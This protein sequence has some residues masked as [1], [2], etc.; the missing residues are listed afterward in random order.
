MSELEGRIHRPF[1]SA[2]SYLDDPEQP[3]APA[4]R[5]SLAGWLRTAALLASPARA[6]IT[7]RNLAIWLRAL[8]DPA[9]RE[10]IGKLFDADFY[11]SSYDDVR[12]AGVHPL[13]HY[14]V[15]GFREGRSPSLLLDNDAYLS[16]YDDV[17][18]SGLNPLLHYALFG[19]GEARSLLPVRSRVIDVIEGQEWISG[20]FA[21]L[22]NVWP[23]GQPLV[24]V[25]IPCFNYGQFVEQALDSVLSQTFANFEVI[26]VEGGSTDGITA[27]IVAG[28]E[29]R[30][31]PKVRVFYRT[32][33]RLVGDNRNFGIAR[34]RGRYVC[35]LDADDL[36]KP[37]YLEMAVFLAESCGFDV[38][39]S[40][41]KCF[42]D[43]DIRWMLYDPSFP[44]ICRHNQIATTALFRRSAWERIGGYRD[45]GLGDEHIP[46]DWDFWVRMLGHGFR[47]KSI[48]EPLMYY[49]V[50]GAGL[51]AT[52]ETDVDLQRDSILRANQAL[53]AAPVEAPAQVTVEIANRWVNLLTPPPDARPAV[54]VALPFITVGGAEQLFHHV[55]QGLAERGAR[56]I[57]VTTVELP[58]SI[59][60][61]ADRYNDITPQ[62]YHL[63]RLLEADLWGDFVRYLIGH[64]EVGGIL[65]AGSEFLHHQL[66]ALRQRFPRLRI[67]DQ[68]FNDAGHI[69][70]NR[71]YAGFIDRTLVPSTALR[72]VLTGQ[73]GEAAERIRVIPHGV[74]TRPA[75]WDRG[76]ALEAAGLPRAAEGRL[77]VSFFGRMSKEK[78]PET[79]VEIAAQLAHRKDLYFLMTG[80][81]PEWEAVKKLA[82]RHK[83]GNSLWMPGFV[84]DPRPLMELTDMVALTSTLDGMPLTVLEAG[85]LG[86][87]VVASRVGSLAEMVID[88]ETGLLRAP[89]DVA[90]FSQAIEM[91]ADDRA[92]R[93]RMG[94]RARQHVKARFSLEAMNEAYAAELLPEAGRRFGDADLHLEL[95]LKTTINNERSK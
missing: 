21:R 92:L 3:P 59:K 9:A 57:I 95:K 13:L 91:L 50:H 56:I 35:C 39:T 78:S 62:V 85:G 11:R 34:A 44:A 33:R 4:A 48:R 42:G 12:K 75:F 26:V 79:F 87:P 51:T 38:V 10:A 94:E 54:L 53:I 45:W 90:G 31:H 40:S 8:A 24:T 46:E 83:L 66:P 74:D 64:Y 61:E 81:G 88:G 63:P 14:L 1:P 18:R 32:E 37:T 25:V 28:I 30:N 17:A 41:L 73:Y 47:T 22:N 76:E 72:D 29:A 52:C 82:A 43:S 20:C 93:I 7:G 58:A 2:S 69:A 86:K 84:D 19:R 68:Q 65:L 16:R 5:I 60:E 23:E 15:C 49:R 89:G 36:L 71:R 67:V 80:E 55:C 70:N 77:L 27:E 6:R